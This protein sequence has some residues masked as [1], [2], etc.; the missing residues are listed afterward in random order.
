MKPR[1]RK[2]AGC[3]VFYFRVAKTLE[4][5]TPLQGVSRERFHRLGNLLGRQVVHEPSETLRLA[6][7]AL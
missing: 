4:A 1:S 7:A 2:R 5:E 6:G 3:G